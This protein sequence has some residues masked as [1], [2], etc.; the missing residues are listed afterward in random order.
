MTESGSVGKW[1]L[2][3]GRRNAGS[4]AFAAMLERS[5]HAR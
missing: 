1:K 5:R 2:S 4:A 3:P